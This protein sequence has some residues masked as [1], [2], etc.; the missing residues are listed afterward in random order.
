MV[1]LMSISNNKVGIFRLKFPQI[2]ETFIVS[3]VL[4][5]DRYS[6][7]FIVQSKLN[8]IEFP[9][10]ALSD[11]DFLKIRQRWMTITRSTSYFKKDPRVKG[12]KIIHAHFGP[13]G[14]YALKLAKDLGIPLVTSFHGYDITSHDICFKNIHGFLSGDYYNFRSVL[15]DR[16][17]A[18]IAVSK[19]IRDR[20]ILKGFSSEKIY[21]H[22]IGVDTT[23]FCPLP[24]SVTERDGSYILNVARHVPKKG[25][26]VL[27]RAFARITE[28]HPHINLLQVGTGPLTQSLMTL[29]TE[30]GIDG[31]VQ[32]LGAQPHDTVLHLMQRALIFALPSQTAE[33]GDSEAL[34]IVFNEASA[35][36]IP[37]VSTWHGGIPEAVLHGETGLLAHE[38]DEKLLAEHLNTLLSD[39]SLAIE[40]GR[41]GREYVCDCY[42]LKKQTKLLEI[43]YD[44]IISKYYDGYKK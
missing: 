42:D 26:D 4:H 18:F 28:T 41:R 34:G 13:D 23:K 14:V 6:P 35:C 3:Q 33:S 17:D 7:F 38:G 36:A 1:D 43:I 40:F 21:Q 27:L 9:Y 25:V 37:I 39:K 12:L 22:Y 19:F 16:G 20:L 5:L 2:S 15:R 24:L 10:S 31:R 11:A 30:L 44:E 8:K 32:F 29:A